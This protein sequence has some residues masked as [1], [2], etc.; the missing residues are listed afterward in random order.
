MVKI[1]GMPEV[2]AFDDVARW[3][4]IISSFV[5]HINICKSQRTIMSLSLYG[6]RVG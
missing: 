1:I 4:H 5:R 3:T 6:Y 2:L